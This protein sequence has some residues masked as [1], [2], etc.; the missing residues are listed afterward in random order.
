M[1]IKK[2]L[3][4]PIETNC[5]IVY[6]KKKKAGV[7]IDPAVFAQ[8]VIDFIKKHDLKIDYI[9]LTHG[10]F[11]HL[12]GAAALA[13]ELNAKICLH[14]DDLWQLKESSGGIA[15]MFGY[16]LE[17]FEPDILLKDSQKFKVG[18]L[19]F[20]VIHT[21]GHSPGGVSFYFEKAKVLFSGDTLFAGSYGRTD[22]PAGD[23]Q[24]IFKS[25]KKLLE[26][27]ENVKVYPGHGDETTIGD[28]KI[29]PVK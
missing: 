22:L 12:S 4:G 3:L 13:K 29:Y 18:D 1:D 8:E 24:E 10:H 16:K 6:D 5:Y 26:L 9:L 2:F 7:N 23:E 21:P 11:D 28:E 27:P 20:K 25:I 15:P 14:P 19:E 17:Y